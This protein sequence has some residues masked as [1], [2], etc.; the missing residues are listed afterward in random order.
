MREGGTGKA[1]SINT[2]AICHLIILLGFVLVQLRIVVVVV[3]FVVDKIIVNVSLV[4]CFIFNH[5]IS[6]S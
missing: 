5:N 3:G 4:D 1:R 2:W 6:I